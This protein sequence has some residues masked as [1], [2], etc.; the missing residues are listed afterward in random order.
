VQNCLKLK[1][2][3][4][5]ETEVSKAPGICGITAEMLI[6]QSQWNP[7]CSEVNQCDWA[8]LANRSD[9]SQLE[10]RSYSSSL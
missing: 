2:K 1:F 5:N 7:W 8:C 9:P 6:A 10:E 4:R 3:L